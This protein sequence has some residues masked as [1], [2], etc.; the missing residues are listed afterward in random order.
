MT[1]P[2]YVPL[3]RW[4]QAERLS[5]RDLTSDDAERVLPLVE[6]LPKTLRDG[7]LTS[8]P[9]QLREAWPGR[10]LMI[11]GTP[12][13]TSRSSQPEAVY[14]FFAGEGNATGLHLT[15]VLSLS[16]GD[17][18]VRAALRLATATGAGLAVRVASSDVGSLSLLLSRLNVRPEVIDLVVDFSI[19]GAQDSRYVS[20]ASAIPIRSRWRSLIF[21]GG[22]FPADLTNLQVGQHVLPRHDWLA[23]AR[24]A[25]SVVGRIPVFGDYTVQHPVYT[26]P[27]AFANFSASIRYASVE[28]W[29]V[30]RGEGVRNPGGAGF[31]QWPANAQLL[32]D[33]PEFCGPTFSR[34]DQYIEEMGT[35]PKTTGSARTWLQAGIGHHVT[36]ASRQ[37]ANLL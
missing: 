5:L 6:V 27:P 35:A 19:V 7:K 3:L 13:G 20:T 23:W 11:D 28:T 29:V 37:S 34:G 12:S 16:D 26:E 25:G 1:T 10:R 21:L 9:K 14:S 17:S 22:A 2:T 24:M 15:P 31:G 4:K 33:R 36:L 8:I 32:R 18:T 30:M